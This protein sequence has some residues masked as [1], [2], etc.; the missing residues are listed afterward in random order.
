MNVEHGRSPARRRQGI[1][2][3]ETRATGPN[4]GIGVVAIALVAVLMLAGLVV[5]TGSPSSSRPTVRSPTDSPTA[6]TTP[7]DALHAAETSLK[8]GSGPTGGSPSVCRPSGGETAQCE[9]AAQ[10]SAHV[11][12]SGFGWRQIPPHPV[13]QGQ[14]PVLMAYDSTSGA[15]LLLGTSTG[16]PSNRPLD[17]KTWAFRS[18]N[19]T[20]MYPV[21]SPAVCRASSLADDPSDLGVLYFGASGCPAAG[22]TWL[23]HA[24]NWT[25][26]TK[27]VRPPDRYSSS[28]SYDSGDGYVLLFGGANPTGHAGSFYFNDTWAFSGGAWSNL[29]ASAGKAPPPRGQAQQVDDRADAAVIL[30]GGLGASW[31]NDTWSFS[32]GS[33]SRVAATG[34]PCQCWYFTEAR[35]VYDAADGYVM[36]VA[37]QNATRGPYELVYRY[38]AGVWGSYATAGIPSDRFLPGL[39]YDAHDHEVVMFGG[40]S[41]APQP[42]TAPQNDTWTYRAGNWT[43]WDGP[44]PGPRISASLAYDAGDGYVLLFGGWIVPP[45]SSNS[46]PITGVNDT[47]KF[48]RGV[49]T[50]LHPVRAPSP[51]FAAGLVDDLAD[52]YL[53]LFGGTATTG[54]S[55]P[56][57]DT[58][59][60]LNGSWA[61]LTPILAPPN[62][63]APGMVYDGADGYVLLYTNTPAGQTWAF[64]GGAWHNL[65]GGSGPRPGAPNNPLVYDAADG[66]VLLFGP[67]ISTSPY[68]ANQTW[69]YLN[70]NWTNRTGAAPGAP[71]ET[72]G[73]EMLYD[74][75]S[76]KVVMLSPTGTTWIYGGGTWSEAYP[77]VAPPARANGPATYDASD[78]YGLIFGGQNLTGWTAPGYTGA[79]CPGSQARPCGDTWAWSPGVGTAL[80]ILSFTVSP[81]AGDIGRPLNLTATVS[82]G[83]VP[84]RY[85]YAGLPPGCVSVNLSKFTCVPNGTGSFTV[86]L[87]VTDNAGNQTQASVGFSVS[88]RPTITGFGPS[89]SQ[90]AVGGRTVIATS[91]SGGTPPFTYS[92]AGLPPG[93]VSQTVPSLPCYPTVSGAYTITVQISDSAGLGGSASAGLTVTPAGAPG[94]PLVSAFVL[95]PAAMTLG[96]ST[97]LSVN[98]SG[99]GAFLRYGYSGLPVGCITVN[100]SNL[101]CRPN[102]AG[103]YFVQA[104]V[105]GA[106]GANVTVGANLTV[107]PVGGGGSPSILAFVAS[108]TAIVLGGSTTLSVVARANLSLSYRYAG[109]PPGC[110]SSDTATLPCTPTAVGNFDVQAIVSDTGGHE[111]GVFGRMTVAPS[112]VGALSVALFAAAPQNLT[113]GGTLYLLVSATGGA[114]PIHYAY[115]GLPPGCASTDANSLRCVPSQAGTYDVTVRLTDATGHQ[116]QAQQTVMVLPAAAPPNAHA[117]VTSWFDLFAAYGGALVVVIG[118]LFGLAVT[119]LATEAYRRRRLAAEGQAL[120]RGMTAESAD[121]RDEVP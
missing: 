44:G 23:F 3:W 83:S 95:A 84:Y 111:V 86:T 77:A 53:L 94:G 34:A 27:S 9:L 109:L 87:T 18:G 59:E 106:N 96:N 74:P 105:S 120:V 50:E 14:G 60:F 4:L 79:V 26:E 91:V 108:P 107:Y 6:A 68:V 71:P 45:F 57:A 46:A 7:A 92:Y 37:A 16:A 22:T 119:A 82:G 85:D 21:A 117:N 67:T 70:G 39:A 49:W 13:G 66:Y 25:N 30:W 69:S 93:C 63:S 24:G 8:T 81:S 28:M 101:T 31:L 58:W 55:M 48:Q 1:P 89:P 113:L 104:T 52:G 11:A 42:G 118:F 61:H 15:V 99:G 76:G 36:L 114:A 43:S 54:S 64:H 19:W 75:A 73:A 32:G 102:S 110:S 88:V 62:Q 121:D 17:S 98:A 38:S 20:E 29:T 51:R 40:T 72:S 2:L 112:G 12:A 103:V 90:L 47:W 100:A 78:G 5:S 35:T 115:T 80:R 56:L 116:A 33:W 65:T 41:Y 10:V 97:N